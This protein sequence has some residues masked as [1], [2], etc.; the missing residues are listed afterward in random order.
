M[1]DQVFSFYYPENLE[2]L[3]RAGA[4]LTFINSLRDRL[5]EIDGLYIGG[6]FPEF[7]LEKLEANCGLRRDI[8]D[9]ADNGLPM[10]EPANAGWCSPR[11]EWAAAHNVLLGGVDFKFCFSLSVLTHQVTW[12]A[13]ASEASQVQAVVMLLVFP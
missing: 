10:C 2:A 4:E 13:P 8:A 9:A 5:P 3:S 7:F 1:L 11:P 12:T 6:G